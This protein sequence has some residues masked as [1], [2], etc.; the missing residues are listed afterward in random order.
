MSFEYMEIGP[1]PANEEC[2][3][4]GADNYTSD[5]ARAEC[6]RF[7]RTIKVKL[8]EPPEGASLVVRSNRHDFGTYYEVAVKYDEAKEAAIDYAFKVESEAPTEWDPNIP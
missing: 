3:Q 1:T 8:G 7:I 6:H 5:G 4:L 2:L